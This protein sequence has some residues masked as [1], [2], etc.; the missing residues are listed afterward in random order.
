MYLIKV[1]SQ[2]GFEYWIIRLVV[3]RKI[4]DMTRKMIYEL[5]RLRRDNQLPKV[6]PSVRFDVIARTELE[7][8]RIIDYA[9]SLGAH[10]C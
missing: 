8:S 3:D 10:P 7:A 9:R 6:D 4:P 5:V 2:D 1:T